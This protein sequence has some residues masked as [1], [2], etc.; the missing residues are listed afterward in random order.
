VFPQIFGKYVLEREMAAGG[1][2]RVYLAT[3]RGAVGFEKRLV[4]KQIRPEL[5]FDEAFVER[6]VAEAKM[7]V[8][9]NHPNIVP[10]YELG[11]EQG[12]FYIAMELCEGVTLSEVLNE[13]GPL[14]PEEGA[15]IGIEICRGL[16]YAHRRA[17]IVHRDVTPRNVML[18]EE[19]AVRLIDFGIAAPATLEDVGGKKKIEVFGSPGHMPPEQILGQRLTPAT[20]VFAVGA[21]LLEAWTGKP[22]FRRATVSECLAALDAK[23]PRL[24][25]DKKELSPLADL[26][27][28]SLSRDPKERPES[29]EYLA[30]P[31]R[32]FVKSA[33][34]GDVARRI[35][36]RVRRTVNRAH[37]S[38]PFAV[39][40]GVTGVS[41]TPSTMK[42]EPR[43][44]AP[45]IG[46]TQTFAARNDLVEWT[47][48][49]PSMPPPAEAE[50]ETE[51]EAEAEPV[52][53]ESHSHEEPQPT[54][55][56]R[57]SDVG[58]TRSR[59]PALLVVAI[60][61]VLIYGG[62]R[63]FSSP[64]VPEPL[65]NS[66]TPPKIETTETVVTPTA[67]KTVA[68]PE[69][70]ENV[71][72]PS[73]AQ[74]IRT[75]APTRVGAVDSSAPNTGLA[76]LTVNANPQS[77]AKVSNKQGLTPLKVTLAPG[78]YSVF[79]QND[80][81]NVKTQAVITLAAGDKKSVFADLTKPSPSI[82]GN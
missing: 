32:E 54:T 46:D 42:A 38:A 60:V 20:D 55:G 47:R 52:E 58:H 39:G 57:T 19:G 43:K 45:S 51:T 82:S 71:P 8:E 3:L 65:A 24:D 61:G 31:L 70:S 41:V 33:D 2:A 80:L 63:L 37:D 6:F 22:P 49:I 4:V 14:A 48:K 79:F 53:D 69:T 30:R 28:S 67:K 7:A 44:R 18:D 29:A 27:G 66:T 76:T 26:V 73:S 56:D 1:M 5:A 35:G 77:F 72:V 16:D 34:L 59:W 11:V 36:E 13:T 25:Q 62:T 9:L 81:L 17:G 78:T 74:P 12:I 68:P 40:E 21:L 64:V 10:V 50:A 23:P 75:T 15:Y